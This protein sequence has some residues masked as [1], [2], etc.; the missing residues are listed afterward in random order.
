VL[1]TWGFDENGDTTLTELSGHR[2]QNGEF[3]FDRVLTLEET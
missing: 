1:G 3:E 2:V